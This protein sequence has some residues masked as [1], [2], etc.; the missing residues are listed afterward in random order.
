M[1]TEQQIDKI[2]SIVKI[3]IAPSDIHGVGVFAIYDIPKLTKL[4]ADSY[5][6]AYKINY[7]RFSELFKE[8]RELIVGRWPRVTLSEPFLWPDSFYQGY[9]NH[10]DFPNYDPI[11]DLTLKDIKAGE[12]ITEDYRRI[13]GW[14]KAHHWLN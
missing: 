10:Y 8:I 2:N 1:T 7:G 11:T 3:K 5:P 13:E 14:E 6:Q 9:I 4:Y 12:E